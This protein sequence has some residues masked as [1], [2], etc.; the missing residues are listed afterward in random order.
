MSSSSTP[1][2][3]FDF[4]TRLGLVFIIEVASLSATAVVL[5]L[6]FI[7]YST[8]KVQPGGLRGWAVSSHIHYYFVNLL[9]C[10]LILSIGGIMDIRWVAE[11][12]VTAGTFC[13]AQGIFKQLGDLGVALS[14]M[15][16]AIHTFLVLV[17]KYYS[18]PKVAPFVVATIWTFLGLVVGVSSAIH[19]GKGYYGPTQYWCWITSKFRTEQIALE[20]GWV[21][22]AASVNI[23][24]YAMIALV[25]KGI[26]LVDGYK[27]RLRRRSDA[28]STKSVT[29]GTKGMSSSAQR[30]NAIAMR[31]LF[32]PAVYLVAIFPMSLVRW[33]SFFGMKVP[34]IATAFASI[35]FSSSGILNVILFTLTRPGLVPNRGPSNSQRS[36][37]LY[38]S[39]ASPGVQTGFR[40]PPVSPRTQA[41][42]S[43]EGEEWKCHSHGGPGEVDVITL[44][45]INTRS[46]SSEV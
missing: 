11:A 40:H 30:S 45:I 12:N 22:F 19:H 39:L 5:L 10:D 21:W 28:S 18:P 32:Y 29:D 1:S 25:L 15:S 9:A 7:C 41:E 46:V 23:M 20:Y 16:I 42:D 4:G 36:C 13:T 31:M 27:I 3:L 14:T 43:I 33:L 8:F 37:E 2:P 26:V 17:F 44:D 38:G 24:C 6:A 35:L 34:F